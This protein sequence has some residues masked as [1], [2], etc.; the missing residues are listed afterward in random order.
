M[1]LTLPTL[2]PPRNK[3]KL[4]TPFAPTKSTS[5]SHEKKT[6]RPSRSAPLRSQSKNAQGGV[7]RHHV[8]LVVVEKQMKR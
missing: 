6:M 7:P 8:V 5:K 1:P 4:Q 2:A 3:K